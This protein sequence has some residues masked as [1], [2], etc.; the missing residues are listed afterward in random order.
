MLTVY[1]SLLTL[2]F[3][4][5]AP[6]PKLD[7]REKK[8][9]QLTNG[10]EKVWILVKIGDRMGG[11]DGKCP[12]WTFK[13]SP[14]TVKQDDLACNGRSK[15]ACWTVTG[16]PPDMFLT[17]DGTKYRL[18]FPKENNTSD[19]EKMLLEDRSGVVNKLSTLLYFEHYPK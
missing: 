2:V 18:T 14:Q 13:T 12:A 19:T 7:E 1:V 10:S 15:E 11:D 17:I 5:Y 3:T 4:L 6:T 8:I 9:Q 16:E